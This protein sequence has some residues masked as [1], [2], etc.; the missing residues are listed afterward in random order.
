MR[1]LL[2]WD[3]L[4]AIRAAAAQNAAAA[5]QAATQGQGGVFDVV[6]TVSRLVPLKTVAA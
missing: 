1:T 4:P 2:R 3:D 6:T 5:L